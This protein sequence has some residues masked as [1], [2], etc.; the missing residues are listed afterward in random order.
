MVKD[1]KY[2]VVFFNGEENID[3]SSGN[4]LE[5]MMSLVKSIARR[6]DM[7]Q[8]SSIEPGA[9]ACYSRRE[10]AMILKMVGVIEQ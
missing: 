4:D 9:V 7:M 3:V 8:C 2:S 5:E 6:H 1:G 10:N